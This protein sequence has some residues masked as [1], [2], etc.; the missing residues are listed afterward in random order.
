MSRMF[1]STVTLTHLVSIHIKAY[2]APQV[3]WY[4][5]ARQL[6]MLETMGI[7]IITSQFTVAW[8]N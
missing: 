8:T 6:P 5:F 3:L 4:Q 2:Q 1:Y 7:S